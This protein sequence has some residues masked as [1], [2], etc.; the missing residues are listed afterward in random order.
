MYQKKLKVEMARHCRNLLS[1]H[2]DTKLKKAMPTAH[3]KRVVWC[4]GRRPL[5]YKYL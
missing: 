3:R 4:V 1:M 2:P 5:P